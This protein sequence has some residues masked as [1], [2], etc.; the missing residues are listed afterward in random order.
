MYRVLHTFQARVTTDAAATCSG[1]CSSVAVLVSSY[2]STFE[3]R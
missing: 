1:L 3:G 2:V